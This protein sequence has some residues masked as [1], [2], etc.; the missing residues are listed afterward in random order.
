MERKTLNDKVLSDVK[1]PE[2][3]QYFLTSASAFSYWQLGVISLVYPLPNGQG[4]LVLLDDVPYLAEEKPLEMV[5]MFFEA[6]RLIDYT[7]M[8]QTCQLLPA[9]P[10]NKVPIVNAHFALFPIEAPENSVWLNPL[11]IA[12][13][14][15]QASDSLLELT[16]GLSLELP[17]HRKTLLRL[18]SRAVYTLATYR[19]DYSALLQAEGPPLSYVPLQD[20]PFG[21]LLSKQELLQQ[22][23]LTPGEFFNQYKQQEYLQWYQSEFNP[24]D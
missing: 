15:S 14:Q 3:W 17:I 12:T 23:L 9:L 22:W 10:S 24:L 20:T 13:V 8:R 4:T 2:D 16:N 18:S 19:Q 5:E 7:L 6:H 11:S 1:L 21:S